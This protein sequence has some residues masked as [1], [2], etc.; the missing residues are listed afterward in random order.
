[1]N[2]APM[3][4]MSTQTMPSLF[5]LPTLV[6]TL[7]RQPPRFSFPAFNFGPT[8]PAA[9]PCQRAHTLLDSQPRSLAPAPPAFPPTPTMTTC[10]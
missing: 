3:E 5:T 2:L 10:L 4:S 9:A 6:S 7:P 8:A 1:M